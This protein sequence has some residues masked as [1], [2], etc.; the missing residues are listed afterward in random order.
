MENKEEWKVIAEAPEFA[1]STKGRIKRINKEKETF[2]KGSLDKDG[3]PRVTLTTKGPDGD[4][5]KAK[6]ITR[7]RHRLVAQAFIPNP[8]NYPQVNHI[9]EDKGNPS[10]DNLEWCT[11]QYNVNYGQG[12]IQRRKTLETCDRSAWRAAQTVYVYDYKTHTFI[13]EF[14]SITTA[15][16]ELDCDYRTIYKLTHN[17]IAARQHHG[18][19]FSFEPIEFDN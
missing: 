19:I 17:Q 11:A 5:P 16:Q 12:A 15:A 2:I 9:D 13:G 1:V 10:V 6:K 4:Y 14:H 7:F 8:N 18:M 3:Y